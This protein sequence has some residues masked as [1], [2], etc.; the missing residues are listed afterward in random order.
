MPYFRLGPSPEFPPPELADPEGLLAIGGDLSVP[1]LVA[2][3]R[4]GIFPWSDDPV[5]TWWSPD[6]RLVLFPAEVKVSR[7]LRQT[8]RRETYTVRFDM[9][10]RRVIRA[11]AKIPRQHED[12]TW[13]SPAFQR[14]YGALHDLGLAHSAEAWEG[15]D[16]VGGLYGVALGRC[17][18]G[19]SM[20][21]ARPDA[22]KV[23]FVA[24]TREL[25]ARGF[26]LIDCQARTEH[27][28]RL[29]A[30]EVPRGEFLARIAELVDVS[31]DPRPWGPSPL[32][33]PSVAIEGREA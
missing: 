15:D 1:R 27:L 32:P 5:I 12:G 33:D 24:L 29:G 4:Q 22:S 2:A 17:F 9:A 13:I 28:V 31:A 8:I 7:S 14:A 11:C 6:P 25:I 10:F 19:E 20:F 30:R 16:L 3:Y 26:E 18:F 21:S 23:A